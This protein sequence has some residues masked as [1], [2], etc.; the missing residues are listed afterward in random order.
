MIRLSTEQVLLLHRITAEETGGS[1]GV[2]DAGLLDSALNAPF[3]TFG[4]QDL[5]PSL[6]GKAA[7]LGHSLIANHP[8]VDGNKRIGVLV[9][10]TF[11][12]LNGVS[13]QCADDELAD[14]G[15]GAA[16]GSLSGGDLEAWI[17]EHHAAAGG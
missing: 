13:V 2:R 15:F 8:F 9:M 14:I 12:E 10:L 6:I 4:G 7:R 16:G 1:S 11:L 3:Q 17:S 5:Y